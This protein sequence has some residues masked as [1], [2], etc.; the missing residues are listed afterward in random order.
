MQGSGQEA[1]LL[2]SCNIINAVACSQA[3]TGTIRV[4]LVV[5]L[6]PLISQKGS[7]HLPEPAQAP[8]GVVGKQQLQRTISWH[9]H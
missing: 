7:R 8:S 4:V 2:P 9:L 3:V 6:G 5:S 1:A